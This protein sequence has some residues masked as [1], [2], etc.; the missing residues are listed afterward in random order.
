MNVR[1]ILLL[2]SVLV[3]L[4]ECMVVATIDRRSSPDDGEAVGSVDGA[5][6]VQVASARQV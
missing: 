2:S 3:L 1:G 5:T 6:V 4:H